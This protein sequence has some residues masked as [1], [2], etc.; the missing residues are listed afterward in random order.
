MPQTASVSEVSNP[1]ISWYAL[2]T[3]HQ[4]EKMLALALSGNGVEVRFPLYITV[5]R[6]KDRDK[7]L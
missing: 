4:H 2:S 6:W 7:Q 5:R 3:R 1:T